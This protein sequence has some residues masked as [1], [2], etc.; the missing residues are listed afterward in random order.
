MAKRRSK[1][2]ATTTRD[3]V[4]QAAVVLVALA[5]LAFAVQGGEY[6]TTD[7]WNQKRRKAKLLTSIDS[8]QHMVDSLKRYKHRLQTDPALQERI[9]RE[10]FG[11]VRG[12]KELLY[13][14][15]EPEDTTRDST[16]R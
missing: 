16:P 12:N 4:K 5:A 6:G 15:A 14:F 8:L 10:E 9:A 11:M 13:R 1:G 7:L 2:G 3:R